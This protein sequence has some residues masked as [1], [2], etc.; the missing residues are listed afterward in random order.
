MTLAA[1]LHQRVPGYKDYL[2]WARREWFS[3]SGLIGPGGLDH[4]RRAHRRLPE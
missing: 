1:R 4:Q 3:A 2:S